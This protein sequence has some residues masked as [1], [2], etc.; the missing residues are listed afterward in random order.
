MRALDGLRFH[1]RALL[2]ENVLVIADLHVGR[3]STSP[4]TLPV[5]DG[6]EMI[7]RLE[8]L[9]DATAPEVVVIAGDL[10]HSFETTPRGIATTIAG[11][12]EVVQAAGAEL[13]VTPGN[14]DTMLDSVWSGRTESAYRVGDTVVCHGHVDPE[15]DAQRYVIGHDHP[16]ISIEGRRRPCFLVGDGVYRGS[17]VVMLPSFN[18]LVSGVEVNELTAADFLSPLV[19]DVDAFAPV[20]RDEDAGETL[21]FPPLGEFRHRL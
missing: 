19:R 6:S 18:R 2:L 8:R 1:D 16:T 9:C 7:E 4:V 14:H 13:I 17:D 20:V 10:L 3:G 15:V 21:T 12:R 5:G 11:L